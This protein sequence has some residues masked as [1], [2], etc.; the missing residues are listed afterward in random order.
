M[1]EL[2]S[3]LV[4]FFCVSNVEGYTAGSCINMPENAI[5]KSLMLRPLA[6]DG[7]K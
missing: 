1:F 2:L 4:F 6:F 7:Y 3:I 5:P